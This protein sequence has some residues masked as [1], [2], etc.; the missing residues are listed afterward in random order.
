MDSLGPILATERTEGTEN[1]I[2]M[3]L[4]VKQDGYSMLGWISLQKQYLSPDF[5][6]DLCVLCG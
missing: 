1:D 3:L 2:Q 5:L 4:L 6:C